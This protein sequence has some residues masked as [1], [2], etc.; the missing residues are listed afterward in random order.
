MTSS[1]ERSNLADIFTSSAS[2]MLILSN[3]IYLLC[4]G[5]TSLDWLQETSIQ[6]PTWRQYLGLR[7]ASKVQ[8]PLYGPRPINSP[9][10]LHL[11]QEALEILR[12]QSWI[13][14]SDLYLNV[15]HQ[16]MQFWSFPSDFIA[17]L[18]SDNIK[19]FSTCAI[20]NIFPQ[21]KLTPSQPVGQIYRQLNRFHP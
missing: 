4:L 2:K 1:W 7:P 11:L 13:L 19:E 5:R 3:I 9:V 12:C 6:T 21:I 18:M 17:Q 15:S 10:T 16:K 14:L 20:T 8:R